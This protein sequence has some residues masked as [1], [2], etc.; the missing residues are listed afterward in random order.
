[1]KFS[2]YSKFNIPLN[3]SAKKEGSSSL[4][5]LWAQKPKSSYHAYKASVPDLQLLAA[6]P[7]PLSQKM[8]LWSKVSRTNQQSKPALTHEPTLYEK[9]GKIAS[10]DYLLAMEGQP[11][12]QKQQSMAEEKPKADGTGLT[13]KTVNLGSLKN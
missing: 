11:Q 12:M 10:M 5:K 6:D 8:S 7:H 3:H 9:K 13:G 4:A 2:L 1:M